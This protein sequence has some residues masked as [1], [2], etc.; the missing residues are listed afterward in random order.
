MV[1]IVVM[2]FSGSVNSYAAEMERAENETTTAYLVNK[3]KGEIIEVPIVQKDKKVEQNGEQVKVSSMVEIAFPQSENSDVQPNNVVT[4]G[5]VTTRIRFNMVYTHS[6]TRYRLD[7][8]NGAYEQID[9]AFTLSNRVVKF[10]S[11]QD[12]KGDVATYNET[13]NNFSHPGQKTW[14]ETKDT[15]QYWIAGYAKCT[16]SRGGSSWDLYCRETV[17]EQTPG[18]L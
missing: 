2:L 1:L 6:G 17:I 4:D 8:V 10:T 11:Q 16:I 5:G 15:A 13:S 9:K 18:S 3:E 14:I 12:F 7:E